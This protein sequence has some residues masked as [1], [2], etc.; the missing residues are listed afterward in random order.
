MTVDSLVQPLPQLDQTGRGLSV[1]Q[2][3]LPGQLGALFLRVD[4]ES[5]GG[6]HGFRQLLTSAPV[7][8]GLQGPVQLTPDALFVRPLVF[9]ISIGGR[10]TQ[11]TQ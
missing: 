6:G 10:H 11:L 4:V 3:T 2:R 8:L 9:V 7:K 5:L 1:G